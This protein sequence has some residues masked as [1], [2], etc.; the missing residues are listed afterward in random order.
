MSFA[1]AR[2][3]AVVATTVILGAVLCGV[4]FAMSTAMTRELLRPEQ[5]STLMAVAFVFVPLFA[6]QGV[7]VGLLDGYALGRFFLP[8]PAPASPAEPRLSPAQRAQNPWVPA[9]IA[10][11]SLGVPFAL[12]ALWGVPRLWPG[13]LSRAALLLRFLPVGMLLALVT[14]L[15]VTGQRLLREL[16]L[17]VAAR[18]FAG[19]HA[20]YLW[21]R[22]ALPQG[23]SNLIINAWVGVA[24]FPGPFDQPG[25][26]VPRELIT[27]DAFVTMLVLALAVLAGTL[28]YASF[29]LR[30]GVVPSLPGVA[31]RRAVR[32]LYLLAPA[33]CVALFVYGL[34]AVL[35]MQTLTFWPFVVLRALACGGYAGLAAYLVASWTLS[36]RP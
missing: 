13:G 16:Q 15:A 9:L 29:D 34:L 26:G 25:A 31:P 14:T 10:S 28:P 3:V 11:A 7:I 2:S 12:L 36:E 1:V 8:A 23:L 6:A 22:H 35:H 30:W 4:G 27:G 20:A 19:S 5:A 32:S 24:I 21:Q 17:P 33:P 18:A